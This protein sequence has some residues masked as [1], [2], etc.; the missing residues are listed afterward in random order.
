MRRD[1][2]AVIVALV[3]LARDRTRRVTDADSQRLVHQSLLGEA[4]ERLG[5]VAVFVWDDDRH[6]VAVNDEACRVT[7]LSRDRLIGMAVG[8]LS[9]DRASSTL[10]AATTQ[11]LLNGRTSFTREDG[12][13]VE[14]DFVTAHTRIAGLPF[15]VSVCWRPVP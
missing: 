1:V 6:Y 8:D 5:E 10:Q 7:G 4:M 9:P 14:L 3:G 13:E 11:S 12:T 15:M 2:H